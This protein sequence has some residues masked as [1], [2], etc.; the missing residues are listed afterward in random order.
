MLKSRDYNLNFYTGLISISLIL[1]LLGMFA[2]LS[3]AGR[4]VVNTTKEELELK[5]ML[6]PETTPKQAFDIIKKIKKQPFVLDARYVSQDMALNEL[7]ELG[8]DFK[9]EVIGDISNY[10]SS[11]NVKIKNEYLN[12]EDLQKI[13]K[14]WSTY[15]QV[16]E[17][18][19][20]VK[21]IEIVNARSATFIAISTVLGIFFVF[22]A[23]LLIMNTI[24]LD[25]YSK[26][27]MIRTMQLIGATS[28][29]IR[30]PFLQL[31][32]IQGFLGSLIAII[33]IMTL[34]IVFT[35]WITDLGII[36]FS[37][38]FL[39]I[40]IFLVAFGTILGYFSSLIAVN[41]YLDKKLEDII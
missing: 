1:F 16:R 13:M 18:N 15:E 28:D 40:C 38:E 5:I 3:V 36:I 19:Y 7:Q 30:K 12:R 31:G 39:S 6:Q 23:Y 17:V 14:E 8:E 29:Y 22:I 9:K 20:P 2:V 21:L 35:L 10:F 25:I 34:L 11:V 26:R 32:M 4:I 27:L 41:R 33:L 24:R 37:M